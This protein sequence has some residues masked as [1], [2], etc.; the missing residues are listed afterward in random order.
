MALHTIFLPKTFFL[1]INSIW[2]TSSLQFG[3]KWYLYKGKAQGICKLCIR[4]FSLQ[5]MHLLKCFC[6]KKGAHR[7]PTW[8]FRKKEA[9]WALNLVNSTHGRAFR[10]QHFPSTKVFNISNYICF[11]NV[12]FLDF[13]SIRFFTYQLDKVRTAWNRPWSRKLK[14]KRESILLEETIGRN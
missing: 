10:K 3:S 4:K 13:E 1:A 14:E 12:R 9:Q 2:N 5:F 7:T 8:K 11:L 6:S